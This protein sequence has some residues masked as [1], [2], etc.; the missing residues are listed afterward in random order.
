MGFNNLFLS[1]FPWFYDIN[2]VNVTFLINF[3]SLYLSSRVTEWR[4][5]V[6]WL[7]FMYCCI[8]SRSKDNISSRIQWM[9]MMNNNEWW[10]LLLYIMLMNL[11]WENN[12]WWKYQIIVVLYN[13]NEKDMEMISFK[14]SFEVSSLQKGLS[15]NDD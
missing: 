9:M 1:H 11:K 15:I 5:N 13:I 10:M 3:S 14:R 7:S 6:P 2:Y 12:L 4:Y 8:D